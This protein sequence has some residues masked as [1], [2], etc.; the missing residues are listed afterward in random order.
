MFRDINF[1][2][3]QSGK[4]FLYPAGCSTSISSVTWLVPKATNPWVKGGTPSSESHHPDPLD[5]FRISHSFIL[6]HPLS[7]LL[8]GRL[9]IKS[10]LQNMT[11]SFSW[12]AVEASQILKPNCLP[13]SS[14]VTQASYITS[15]GLSLTFG[16]SCRVGRMIPWHNTNFLEQCLAAVTST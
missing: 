9:M 4:A 12:T 14:C 13:L 8:Q 7:S 6:R 2:C 5:H 16:L 3:N 10:K 11:L 1:T 15:L